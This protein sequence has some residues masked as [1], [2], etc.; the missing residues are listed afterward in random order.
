MATLH[1]FIPFHIYIRVFVVVWYFGSFFFFFLLLLLLLLLFL[2]FIAVRRLDPL[3]SARAD[4]HHRTQG[5][6]E[7]DSR[8]RVDKYRLNASSN[9]RLENIVK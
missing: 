3:L 8:R 5:E 4:S 7:G 9:I 2:L 1:L 6:R